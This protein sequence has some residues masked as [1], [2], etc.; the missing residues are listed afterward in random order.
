MT[1]R[2]SLPSAGGAIGKPKLTLRG[3]SLDAIPGV[4]KGFAPS[5][6][7]AESESAMDHLFRP[8]DRVLHKKFG[9]GVVREISGS[10]SAAR[11][12]IL[13]TAYGEK[14][15]ALSIAPIVKLED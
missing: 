10:G 3:A 7:R 5:K 14:E 15:F 1:G 12:R 11:I 8:G 6:A 4:Q 13:F 2:P 9:A